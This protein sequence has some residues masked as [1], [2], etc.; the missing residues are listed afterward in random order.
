[1][2]VASGLVDAYIHE[3]EI[4]KWD[5]CAGNAILNELGGRMTTKDGDTI[6]YSDIVHKT[7]ENGL[8]ATLRD[9]EYFIKK[10]E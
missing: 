9:H 3:T 8:I 4:K 10:L 2:Q 7:N 6:N 1:M 5:I